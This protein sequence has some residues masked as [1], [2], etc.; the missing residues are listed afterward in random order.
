[1]DLKPDLVINIYLRTETLDFLVES[2]G[3]LVNRVIAIS[4]GACSGLSCTYHAEYSYTCLYVM[5][6]LVLNKWAP[7]S[8]HLFF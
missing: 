8:K 1:M 4:F 3:S 6:F 2:L 5:R 7:I